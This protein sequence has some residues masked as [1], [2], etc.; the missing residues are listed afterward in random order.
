MGMSKDP[1]T[2]KQQLANLDKAPRDGT[3]GNKNN[4]KHGARAQV[5]PRR[6]EAK[7]RELY[8]ELAVDVPLQ[9]A[10]GG[11]LPYDRMMLR[12][13]AEALCR[14]EDVSR[15]IDE[16]GFTDRK[17]RVR[18]V[19]KWEGSI[20]RQVVELLDR[21]G[22]SPASRARIGV[23]LA[24]QV[25]LADAMSEPDPEQRKRKLRDA[26]VVDSDAEEIE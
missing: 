9:A 8:D 18:S 17:G 3:P 25:D 11:P 1:K 4:L 26:G 5:E 14:L 10:G 7:V 15:W 19:L 16:H 22:M 6:L 13:L 12:Q 24:R 21:L 23:D 2:R 20:R